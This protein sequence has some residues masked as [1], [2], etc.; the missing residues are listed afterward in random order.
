LRAPAALVLASLLA[1]TGSEA[2]VYLTRDEALALAF[3]GGA[4]IERETVFLTESQ[5]RRARELAGEDVEIVGAL[6]ARYVG[7][8]GGAPAG[9]AYFDTHLVRTLEE[10]VMVVVTP[11]GRVGRI[12]ILSFGEPREYLPK[13][14]WLQQFP[15]REL[16]R[17]LRLQRGLHGITGATLSA[18]AVTGAA[19]RILAIHRC[20][21][22]AAPKGSPEAP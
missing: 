19:R 11:D 15:G 3:G 6:V 9:T 8:V 18:R 4:G 10:T 16:D 13:K 5:L 21:L 22:E 12:E 2:K 17:D 1:S 14:A 20:L 7:R